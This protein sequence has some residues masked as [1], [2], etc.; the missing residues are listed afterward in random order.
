MTCGNP[1]ISSADSESSF[2][3]IVQPD[4]EA[5]RLPGG[6]LRNRLDRR[7][8]RPGVDTG[9]DELALPVEELADDEEVDQFEDPLG[10][11]LVVF[12]QRAGLAAQAVEPS[13]ER[14]QGRV[15]ERFEDELGSRDPAARPVGLAHGEGVSGETE[16][17]DARGDSREVSTIRR[18]GGLHRLREWE[19]LVKL[20]VRVSAIANPVMSRRRSRTGGSGLTADSPA[21]WIAGLNWIQRTLMYF[22]VRWER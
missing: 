14:R 3:G 17:L 12:V 18:R 8:G 20:G 6:S 15:V 13:L 22:S 7:D 9:L 1:A 10:E 21:R 19:S 4:E 11:A 16:R 2:D 5:A